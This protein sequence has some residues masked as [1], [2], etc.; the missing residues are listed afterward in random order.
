M[1]SKE[2]F[3]ITIDLIEAHQNDVDII[4]QS[5]FNPD[6]KEKA[7]IASKE[8]YER[9]YNE[10]MMEEPETIDAFKARERLRIMIDQRSKIHKH[11]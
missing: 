1:N 11:L 2:K 7:V 3:E 10:I 8:I 9:M 5:D 4:M 6:L